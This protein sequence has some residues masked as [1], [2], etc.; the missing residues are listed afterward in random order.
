M[1]QVRTF[2]R[3]FAGGEVTPEFFSQI[4]DAKFQTGL[5]TCRNFF[6]KPHG[7]VENR[8]GTEFVRAAKHA[9]K[10]ARL[11][12][13]TYS[14]T[15]TMVLGLATNTYA[16]IHHGATLLYSD[17]AAWLT[18]TA[19]VVGDIRAYLGQNYYCA[20]AHVRHLC[21]RSRGRQVALMPSDPNIYEIPSPYAE[22][23]LF[24]IHYTQS[25]DVLTLVHPGYAPRELRR[26]GATDWRLVSIAFVPAVSAPS[27]SVK[28]NAKGSNYFYQ[29]VVND[30]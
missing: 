13:F 18:A 12:P 17:G 16:S 30:G 24:A 7:P 28:G 4:E 1:A 6:V 2:R 9:D 25:A 15:Q 21:H 10:A 11:I 27:V 26:Y 22:A 5:A 19:Y 3:S 8:P 20:I 23:D 14:T 29:Y